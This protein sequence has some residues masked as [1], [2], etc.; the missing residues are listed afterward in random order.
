[1]IGLWLE[2][3]SV[4]GPQ[5]VALVDAA[6][7]Q[8]W[9]Y[10][11]LHARAQRRAAWLADQ[12]GIEPG[13]R[14]CW[15]GQNEPEFFELFFA[16]ARLGAILV[17]I[18][19]RLAPPEVQYVV[20]N[21]RPKL[22]VGAELIAAWGQEPAPSEGVEV[23]PFHARPETPL[24]I[25][26]TSG[27]TGRPKGAVLTH[28]SITANSLNTSIA[29]DLRSDDSTATFTPLF[30]T[31]AIN[32]LSLPLLHRGGKVVLFPRFD[33][34][35]ILTQVAREQVTILF[36]VPTT[37]E[38]LRD[39]PAFTRA[40]LSSVRFS[41]C[42]GAPCP[43][44]LIDDYAARGVCFRQGYGLTEVGPNCFSLIPEEAARK[45]GT[46]G[47]P[48]LGCMARLVAEDGQEVTL[49]GAVGELWLAGEHV[50]AGY[51]E[52]EA[53]SEASRRPG[54]WWATGDLFTRDE[55]GFYRV[56]GRKKEMF[57]SGG[58][59]VYPAEVEAAILEH[60]QV[61]ECVVIG[62]PDATWGEIGWAYVAPETL[63]P[64]ALKEFLQARLARYK[65]PKRIVPVA[66]LPRNAMGK[67]VRAAIAEM[68]GV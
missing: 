2:K 20:D 58:E 35:E 50:C 40:D 7:G 22:V 15:H 4:F 51:W 60:P 8:R 26:H 46:V 43:L 6:S 39:S 29:C 42:G 37:F 23:A 48:V 13:D 68:A 66:A 17:P 61:T 55:E 11:E 53:A 34:E 5:R 64:D 28:G 14:V 36:G 56:V 19:W 57:I 18:N 25:L 52:D 9:S 49:P 63:C 31:G 24:L 47:F 16:C 12:A 45:A 38:M 41:L 21:V 44:K 67:V 32:V 10:A 30:H 1:M 65:Q 27:T 62:V 59:N 54:G 3:W 33:A